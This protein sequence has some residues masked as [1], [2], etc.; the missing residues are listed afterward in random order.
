MRVEI[1]MPRLSDAMTEGTVT[2][3]FKAEGDVVKAGEAIAELETEKSTVDLEASADGVLARIVVA[4][5]SA[6]VP[7]GALLA[8]IETDAAALADVAAGPQFGMPV[9]GVDRSPRQVPSSAAPVAPAIPGTADAA[10]PSAKQDPARTISM[11]HSPDEASIPATPLARR[12]AAQ[13]GLSLSSL[14][15]TG[16]GGKVCKADVEAAVGVEAGVSTAGVT[17]FSRGVTAPVPPRPVSS[18]TPIRGVAVPRSTPSS[19]GATPLSRVRRTVAERMSK[20]KSTIPHFY[21]SSDCRVD[22]LLEVRSRLKTDGVAV[23]VND[24]VVR[25]AALALR[26][27]PEANASWVDG[28]IQFHDRVDIAVAVALDDGLVTPVVRGADT[29]GLGAIAEGV[30][31]LAVR[32]REGR[33]APHEYDGGTFTVSNLGMF[34]VR[35]MFAIVNPPQACI[36]GVGAAEPRPVVEGGAVVAGTVMML[37]ISADHRVLDGASGA[38]LL[39]EIRRLLEEPARMLV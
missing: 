12:M 4:A 27:F 3:W 11:V 23:S 21:L 29:L 19:M 18:V 26:R 15:R 28:G 17:A 8:E 33:L 7:V 32:A 37:S 2:A 16:V 22:R 39:A 6:A 13:A 5:G 30:R 35:E 38:R 31:D 24:F 14:A 1:V 20:S 36:L 9:T 25:A 10:S 34:G